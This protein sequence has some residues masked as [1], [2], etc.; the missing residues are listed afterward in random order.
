MEFC[1]KCGS[2]MIPIKKTKNIYLHCK[3]CKYEVQGYIKSFKFSEK[4]SAEA[5]VVVIPKQ[6]DFE[7]SLPLTD[8][9]CPKC[10]HNKVWWWVQQTRSIDEPPTQFYRCMKCGHTWR[11]YK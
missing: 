4:K 6:K 8:K 1:P 5:K 2:L 3:K 7:S 11:E 10:D 9:I